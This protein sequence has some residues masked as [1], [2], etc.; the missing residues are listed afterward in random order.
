MQGGGVQFIFL[1]GILLFLELGPN[2]K[3]RN[4]KQTP[5]GILV[6]V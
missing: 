1:V 5:S 2:A 4:P 6:T 3:F